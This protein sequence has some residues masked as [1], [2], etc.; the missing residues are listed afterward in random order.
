MFTNVIKK[1]EFHKHI[2]KDKNDWFI[3]TSQVILRYII[4]L[5]KKKKNY[6]Y[7]DDF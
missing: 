3:T 1:K 5:W 7:L 2:L 6:I 4:Y